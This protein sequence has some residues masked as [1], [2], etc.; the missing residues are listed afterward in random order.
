M[1]PTEEDLSAVLEHLGKEDEEPLTL[2]FTF[3]EFA[4]AADFL[5]PLS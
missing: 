3:A 1:E 5:S 4:Q 2:A